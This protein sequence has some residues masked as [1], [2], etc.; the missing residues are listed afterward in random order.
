M[1]PFEFTRPMLLIL[2]VPIAIVLAFG[3]VRSL[4]DFPRSQRIASL[5]T[6][7]MIGLLLVLALAGLTWLHRTNEQF[8]VFVV[9]QSLSVGDAGIGVELANVGTGRRAQRGRD[10]ASVRRF[11][12]AMK[13]N[14]GQ[15]AKPIICR[16]K[17]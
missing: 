13:A 12:R 5:V 16:N 7:S 4:S 9:D 3:F 8:V 14:V 1:L 11:A 17:D 2:I 10:C 6:R 15:W